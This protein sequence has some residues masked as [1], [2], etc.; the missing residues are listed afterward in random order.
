MESNN[1]QLAVNMVASV[2]STALTY[3]VSFFLT[4]YIVSKL[5]VAAY[6]FVGLAT[7]IIGYS[8]LVT[9]VLNSMAGR[10]ITI[11]Y[12]KGNFEKANQYYSSVFYGNTIIGSIILIASAIVTFYL[13]N[14]I[15]I[16]DDLVTDVKILFAFLAINTVIGLLFSVFAVAPFIRN[17]LDYTNTRNIIGNFLRAG[18]LFSMFVFLPPEIWYFGFTGLITTIYIVVMNRRFLKRLTPELHISRSNFNFKAIRELISLGVWNLVSKCSVTLEKGLNLLI[19]NLFVG[20]KLTG[21]L[22]LSLIVP[23][24]VHGICAMM[25]GNFAPSCTKMYAENNYQGIMHEMSKSIRIMGFLA[26]IPIAIFIVEGKQFFHLWVP[27][28]NADLLYWLSIAGS[29]VMVVAMPLE[30]LWNIFTIFNKVKKSSL[31]LLIW[32]IAMLSTTLIGVYLTDSPM[33]RLFIIASV[34]SVYASIRTLTFLPLYGAK[35]LQL[36]P[37]PFYRDILRNLLSLGVIIIISLAI[38]KIPGAEGWLALIIEAL[39]TAVIGIII[40]WFLSLNKTDRQYL[41][42]EFKRIVLRR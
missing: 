14:L 1:R 19:A 32:S 4:P 8:S 35:C 21:I 22:S 18:V 38:P 26:S 12:H 40:N 9:I 36:K 16:P 42:L 31:N 2:L 24:M 28:E 7:Q 3:I 5:G 15:N 6:G 10:F 17:R 23:G 30:P 33:I 37:W 25:A 20:A 27:M 39:R 34:S 41:T 11:Q 13:N 29:F